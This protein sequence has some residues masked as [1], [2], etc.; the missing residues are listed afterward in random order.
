MPTMLNG[1]GVARHALLVCPSR[2]TQT[3]TELVSMVTVAVH[4]SK[5][6]PSGR[7]NQLHLNLAN[8]KFLLLTLRRGGPKLLTPSETRSMQGA[9]DHRSST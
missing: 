6:S 4:L 7:L 2:Y 5:T 8:P 3:A 1:C 9:E